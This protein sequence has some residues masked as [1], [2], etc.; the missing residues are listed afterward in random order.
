MIPAKKPKGILIKP[1]FVN[2]K[3]AASPII[4]GLNKINNT[5]TLVP[6]NM[7]ATAPFVLKRFQYIEKIITGKLELAPTAKAYVTNCATL[8][9]F[10]KIPRMIETTPITK[11]VI[12]AT[13]NC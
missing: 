13:L 11:A 10:A 5:V 9:F 3:I 4:G 1:G 8:K 6:V 7:D 2:G 12:R